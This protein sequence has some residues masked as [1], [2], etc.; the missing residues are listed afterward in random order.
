MN[1]NSTTEEWQNI[2]SVFYRPW[3]RQILTAL[4]RYHP[5]G[6]GMW[7]LGLHSPEINEGNTYA[8]GDGKFVGGFNGAPSTIILGAARN[9]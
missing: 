8:W 7:A 9:E 6:T 2:F 5:T 1:L 4:R 3:I